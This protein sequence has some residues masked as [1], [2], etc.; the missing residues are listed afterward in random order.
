MLRSAIPG[1][2]RP[3]AARP[4]LAFRRPP[5]RSQPGALEP[6]RRPDARRPSLV[7]HT[8]PPPPPHFPPPPPPPLPFLEGKAAA[9]FW[10]PHPGLGN[11]F[12]SLRAPRPG[13]ATSL[14]ARIWGSRLGEQHAAIASPH[15]S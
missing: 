9:S 11:T 14:P 6:R 2:A 5:P 13:A 10:A 8:R 1:R 3:R 15:G 12:S 7:S 4:R